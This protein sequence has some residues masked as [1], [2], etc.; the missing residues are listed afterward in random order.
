MSLVEKNIVFEDTFG[1][2]VIGIGFLLQDKLN[3]CHQ[4]TRIFIEKRKSI[5]LSGFDVDLDSLLKDS[6]EKIIQDIKRL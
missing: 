1:F 5:T 4:L 6:I 2:D 3:H